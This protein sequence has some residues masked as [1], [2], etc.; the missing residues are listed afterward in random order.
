MA[1]MPDM[2]VRSASGP[3]VAGRADPGVVRVA[4]WNILDGGVGRADPLAEVLIAHRPDVVVLPEADDADVAARLGRRL[5]MDILIGRGHG[6]AVAIASRWPVVETINH[7]GLH[8]DGPRALLEA[9]VATPAGLLRVF[10]VHFTAK[11][12]DESETRREA[13]LARLL[14]I[15]RPLRDA[16]TPHLLAGDFNA[17]APAQR[18][19]PD[20]SHPRTK[21]AWQANGG[22]IPRRVI[23]TLLAAGYADTLESHSPEL[24]ATGASFTTKDPGQ[25]VDYVF[26]FGP[27][28][29][30]DAWVEHDHLAK[31]A[32]DHFPVG[33][34]LACDDWGA[35]AA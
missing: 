33:A 1:V 21:E 28:A 11:A 26:A 27:V 34:E 24:A 14:A 15:T 3:A 5:D 17:N 32:S 4:A 2:Q 22:S 19:D 10:G 7:G 12:F 35:G 23:R 8:R 30:R 13:E 16:G 18:I 9:R 6:S 29:V 20:R 25:R 31:F